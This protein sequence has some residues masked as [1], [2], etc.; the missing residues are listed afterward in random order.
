MIGVIPRRPIFKTKRL[1]IDSLGSRGETFSKKMIP[2]M[3]LE[4]IILE[5]P[6]GHNLSLRLSSCI[7]ILENRQ[8]IRKA[9]LFKYV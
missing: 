9:Q 4:T 6:S 7:F 3:K 8:E 5:T 2:T 1:S